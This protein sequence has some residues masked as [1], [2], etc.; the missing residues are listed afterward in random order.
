MKLYL[1]L[2]KAVSQMPSVGQDTPDEDRG[3]AKDSH[4]YGKDY[5]GAASGDGMNA[6]TVTKAEPKT[7]LAET[8]EDREAI[9]GDNENLVKRPEKKKVDKGF[10]VIPDKAVVED[11]DKR[12]KD[13]TKSAT[14]LVDAVAS[15]ARYLVSLQTPNRTEVEFLKSLGYTEEDISCGNARIT[16]MNR[17]NF[18]KWLQANLVSALSDLTKSVSTL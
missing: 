15:R 13:L 18:N 3:K 1:D 9:G 2:S 16:G 7:A 14:R 5:A 10:G 12:Q 8:E 17:T 6:G 4:S 11:Y